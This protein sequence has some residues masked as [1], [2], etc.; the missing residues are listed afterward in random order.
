M[1]V[2]RSCRRSTR[3][4]R[5]STRRAPRSAS[6]RSRRSA[7]P[8]WRRPASRLGASRRSGSSGWR[9]H[10]AAD[11]ALTMPRSSTRG[12][13][14]QIRIGIHNGPVVAGVIGT[15]KFVYDLWG[16]AVNVASRLETIAA[17]GRIQVS[18]SIAAA[19]NRDVRRRA[20]RS[21]RTSRARARPRPSSSSAGRQPADQHG[22]DDCPAAPSS[23]VPTRRQLQVLRAYIAAGSLAGAAHTLGS[24][25][26]TASQHLSGLSRRTGCANVAQAA[27]LLGRADASGAVRSGSLSGSEG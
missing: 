17:A 25:E 24:A 8:T 23:S 12:P 11:L 2:R 19:S 3:C 4:S 1:P 26:T 6:R 10:A 13:P 15:N 16:D 18:A 9:I 22:G 20:P 21:G 7:T 27:Y 5:P 14:W